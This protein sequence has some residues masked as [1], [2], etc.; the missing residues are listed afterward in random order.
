M[1]SD[2]AVKPLVQSSWSEICVISEI[3]YHEEKKRSE[4]DSSEVSQKSH[5]WPVL[6]R[7]ERLTCCEVKRNIIAA[8][9]CADETG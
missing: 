7:I 1:L 3:V 6:A 8:E 2:F 9:S 4:I 5:Q